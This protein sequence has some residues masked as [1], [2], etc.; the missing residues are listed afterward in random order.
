MT[1]QKKHSGALERGRPEN[2]PERG[3]KEQ[4]SK[5]G[6]DCTGYKSKVSTNLIGLVSADFAMLKAAEEYCDNLPNIN[7]LFY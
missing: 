7:I 2:M 5:C 4:A 1:I 3:S 6:P